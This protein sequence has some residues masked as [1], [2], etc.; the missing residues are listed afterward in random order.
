VAT[1]IITNMKRQNQK[2]LI[3]TPAYYQI[4]MCDITQCGSFYHYIRETCY[5]QNIEKTGLYQEEHAGN[6]A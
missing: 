3:L 4:L 6:F 5:I 1:A 2:E